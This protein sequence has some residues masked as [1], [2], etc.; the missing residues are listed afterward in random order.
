MNDR[1][2]RDEVDTEVPETEGEEFVPE[3]DRIIGQA[4]RWSLVVIVAIGAAVGGYLFFT[5][6]KLEEARV[7][8][9]DL[10]AI[11][12]LAPALEQAPT[13]VFRDVTREAGIEF[14]HHNG[15]RGEKLL[16]ETMGSGCAFLDYDADGDQDL[17]LTNGTAW[18]HDPQPETPPVMALYRNDGSGHFED[19]TEPAG[20]AV[21]FYGMGPAVA[22][23]DADG[24]VDLF[25]AAVG[26][27]RMFRNDGGSFVDIT[28]E[29]G[30][31]GD[32]SRWGSSAGFFDADGD[33]DLD[34]LVG[35]YVEWSREIDAQL[36]FTL[37][38]EDRAYGPPT[39]YK[40]SFSTLYRNDGDSRF[41]DV[42]EESGIR[43]V[44]QATGVPVAKTLGLAFIDI[45][46][47]GRQDVLVA[48]DTVSN[49]LF[50]N[51]GDGKFEEIG[52]VA[53]VAY[54]STGNATGAMGIDCSHYR[55]D[56]SLGIGIG[57][58]ANEMSSL[59]VSYR[60]PLQFSDEAIGEGVGSPSRL[61][62]SFGLFFFD[63][64]LDG[65]MDLFQAN[66][67][68]EET[69]HEIQESQHY[70]QPPQLF[71]NRGPESESCFVE[72]P[73][74]DAGD[75]AKEVAGRAAAYADI[76]GDGD[77]D[78]LVTQP[79]DRPL[80][81]RNDQDLGHHWLRLQLAG[82]GGNRDA[83]GARIRVTLQGQTFERRVGPTR[84]YLSQVELPV[85]IGLGKDTAVDKLEILWPDGS[86]QS[87]TSPTLDG[88]TIVQ[89]S[90]A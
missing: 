24:D 87:V 81:L 8:E 6:E 16:P 83:I 36:A 52:D 10:S 20:L 62:L 7:Q 88:T 19:V 80:L 70:H 48:N 65:R 29:A 67:H 78:V 76:D 57:N 38:G 14:V 26:K 3:D 72:I 11:P 54:D 12:D 63:Y 73:G 68:L 33:G 59:Y 50:H 25:V 32:P 82:A 86:T 22:D 75:L 27:N 13:V 74:S 90:G 53:G 23:W 2:M 28:D 45:D 18:P 30:V 41:V 34:L 85:T 64:D 43:V 66:G 37:N 51:L 44:N 77:L 55:N 49:F 42:S 1:N 4:F 84:S 21:S 89:Q 15:A 71:W 69:I 9:K 46:R 61:R 58:F 56:G 35:H 40:G 39:N 79:G 5:T 47:D 17:L 60:D 31:A